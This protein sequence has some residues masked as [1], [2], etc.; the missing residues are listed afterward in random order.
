MTP[1]AGLLIAAFGFCS[2]S[3]P[4]AGG[5]LAGPVKASVVRIVDGDTL[6]VRAQI[7]V[8][9]EIDVK[10]RLADADAPELYRPRCEAEKAPARAAR[11]RL[12][13]LAGEEVQ[14]ADIRHGRRICHV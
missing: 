5:E 11:D 9:Q 1:P 3:A 10:L 2:L 14:L 7:W 4:A 6:A 8:D 12:R 13:V